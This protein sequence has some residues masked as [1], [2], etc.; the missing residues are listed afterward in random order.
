MQKRYTQV[1]AFHRMHSNAHVNVIKLIRLWLKH[2]NEKKTKQKNKNIR[3]KYL[4]V[5]EKKKN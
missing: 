2:K 4:S 1:R 3:N 5:I